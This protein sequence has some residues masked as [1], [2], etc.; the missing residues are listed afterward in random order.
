MTKKKRGFRSV[1][2]MLL[3]IPAFVWASPTLKNW[4]EDLRMHWFELRVISDEN[5]ANRDSVVLFD[6]PECEVI[7]TFPFVETFD[8]ASPTKACWTVVNHNE[9]FST[10]DLNDGIEPYVGDANPVM[11][12]DGLG[13]DND[14]W[15]ISPTIQLNG[16]QRLRY[17]YKVESRFEPNDFRVM[18]STSGTE[19]ANFTHELLPL[20]EYDNTT[21]QE[22]MIYLVDENGVPFTG[23]VNLAWHVPPDGLD[24]WRLYIDNVIV[25]DIPPCPAPRN[26]TLSNRTTM[27]VQVDWEQG[28]QE[29]EWEVAIPVAGTLP[30]TGTTVQET[31]FTAT[32]LTPNTVYDVYVRAKCDAADGDS[33]WV[34]PIAFRTNMIPVALPFQDDFE[35]GDNFVFVSEKENKWN[36]GTAVNNGGTQAMY[37]SNNEG[38]NYRYTTDDDNWDSTRSHAYK[39][40]T[41]GA[42]TNELQLS[43]DWRCMG[44][45]DFW[46]SDYFKVWI[47]PTDYVIIPN[48]EIDEDVEGVMQIGESGYKM[49]NTFVN[50]LIFFDGTPYAG[51][52]L[53]LVFEWI[54]DGSGG[55]QPPAA[56]DNVD[57]RNVLCSR[58]QNLTVNGITSTGFT[59]NW[60]AVTGVNN[61][62]LLLRTNPLQQPTDADVATHTATGSTY[63]FT[64]LTQG[65]FYYVWLRTACDATTKSKWIGPIA[66]NIPNST[67]AALPYIEEF[68]GDT[69]F[70]TTHTEN[71]KW[72]VGNAVSSHGSRSLYVTRTE[73]ISNTYNGEEE[74]AIHAF[75]D[76]VIPATSTQLDISFTWRAVGDE[77]LDWDTWENIPGD[78]MKV[79]IVPT[80]Y[81]PT[82]GTLITASA[83]RFEIEPNRAFFLNRNFVIQRN[84]I[85]STALAGQT[86]RIVFEWIQDF[87]NEEQPP[88]AIDNLVIKNYTCADVTNLDALL[89]ENTNDF[90]ITWTPGP[91]QT[92]WE[93]FIIESGDPFPTATDTGIIVEGTP[94]YIVEDVPEETFY[95]VFVRPICSDTDKG[96]WT[97]P[98]DFSIFHPPGCAGI[99]LDDI[100]LNVSVD[101]EYIICSD[102][103]YT[104]ELK[105]NYYDIKA[106]TDYLVEPIEYA[107]PFP[108]F[109]GDAVDLTEDDYWSGVIDLGFDF[110]FYGKSYNKAIIC[111]NG[112][113]SFSIA[114]E[115]D[116]GRYTPNDNSEWDFEEQIP[117]NPA[118]G[119]PPFVNA[120]FGVLQDSNPRESPADYSVNYQI[121]GS[122]PCRAL[123]FNMYHMGMFDC[124]YDEED[125]EGTTTTTQMVLYEGTN[126]VEVYVKNRLPCM[127]W[128]DGA[129]LLG[130]QNEDG[131]LAHFPPDR[132]TGDWET[133][134]EAWRFTPNGESIASFEWLRNGEVLTTDTDITVTIEESTTY[135]G[136]ITYEHCNGEEM[137]IEK[138]FKFLKEPMILGTPKTVFD[139]AKKPG[140]TY[141]YNLDENIPNVLQQLNVEDFTIEYY[142]TEADA[143]NGENQLEAIHTTLDPLAETIFMK[144]INNITECSKTVNFKLGIN[145]QLGA[146]KIKDIFI[147]KETILPA[148]AEGEAYYTAPYGAGTRYNAGDRYDVVGINTLYVY[149]EDEKQCYGESNFKIEV[150][151]EVFAPVLESKVL[152]CEVFTLPGLPADSKYYTGEGETGIELFEGYEVIVPMTIYIVTRNGNKTVYC[153]DESSFTI[154]F[155]DCPLPKG[156][157]PNGD[158]INDSFD[159]TEYGV[160]KIQVFN[161]NG[162]EVYS[163]G[164]GYKNEWM[165]QDKSGNKLP[166]GTYYYV[167]VSHGK[168]KTGWVQLNY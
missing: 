67:A 71:N 53:R 138:S 166:T 145:R 130:M 76:F 79:W 52:T 66:V 40:F 43:F 69:F 161:R 150:L 78:F 126:I 29:E 6:D 140:S 75:K 151:P 25:E 46:N 31:T 128:L 38:V 85:P 73:G 143:E 108:F 28:Y 127:D 114:G 37:I 125:I 96:W 104:L 15:L 68:E 24:G 10:W 91:G 122:Y 118:D 1:V 64:N 139:C 35:T 97:G 65:S 88:A 72:V 27:G 121:I 164:L 101:G 16:N 159:L 147:C 144:V 149:H 160:A 33:E 13:G 129:G 81:T 136:R 117:F 132:N 41:I 107:P 83:D 3:I 155:E 80:S 51:E 116:G 39:D 87:S 148:L 105:A 157:S 36:R 84:V 23:E 135:T 11:T 133:Q 99:T 57:L 119:Y 153:Y 163:H 158:G 12:T 92:K 89:I 9:D 48:E 134:N 77:G 7:T 32:Q 45:G 20:R 109:G 94:S 55:N 18:L 142:A 100:E 30:T 93:V 137:V 115:V 62:D 58:P 98:K 95:K 146:T 162:V 154:D 26:I 61:Y 34:G 50:E 8:S 168:L 74:T 42:D 113:I 5:S 49:N 90:E 110:C 63:A 47:V 120:I 123:V 59:A 4:M 141:T 17:Y 86:K 131:T 167:I 156:F 124:G 111:T 2:L 14:D 70:R 44:E 112:A 19:V 152:T 102:D 56:I 82:A 103:P 54:N 21:Y 22:E 106:T 60:T 165:G